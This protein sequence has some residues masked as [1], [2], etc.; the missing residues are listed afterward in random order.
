MSGTVL[1][2]RFKMLLDRFG[3]DP[4]AMKQAGVAYAV[5]QIP[6]HLAPADPVLHHTRISDKLLLICSATSGLFME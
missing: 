5:S 2:T 6:E 3:D 4:A 1:P